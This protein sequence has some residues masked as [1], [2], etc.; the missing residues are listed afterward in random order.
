MPIK[1][2]VLQDFQFL[3]QDKKIIILKAKTILE[4]YTYVT[5]TDR[6]LITEDIVNNNPE[7][8]LNID[9][10]MDFLAEIKAAKIPQPTVISKKLI[11]FVENLL[12]NENPPVVIEQN[13]NLDNEI[14]ELRKQ[15]DTKDEELQNKD[16]IISDL[17]MKL[18][19]Q[20]TQPFDETLY[21]PKSRLIAA[22]DGF[23]QAGWGVDLIEKFVNSL[24]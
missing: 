16:Q 2:K 9:W 15:L 22:V 8:F 17:E 11:P 20:Q 18:Q 6:V 24:V 14:F 1:H 7:Y 5:K 13:S 21:V 19:T 3:Q 23:R 12:S 10:K 4:D